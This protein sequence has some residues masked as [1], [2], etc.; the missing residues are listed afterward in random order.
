MG[1]REGGREGGEIV[2]AGKQKVVEGKRRVR[3]YIVID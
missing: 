1:G 3:M 2:C